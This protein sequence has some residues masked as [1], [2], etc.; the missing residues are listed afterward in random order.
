M[1]FYI[2]YVCG[3]ENNRLQQLDFIILGGGASGLQ[4]AHR[5]S[6]SAAHKASSILSL[7]ATST[8]RT[9][10]LGVFGKQVKE[11][12]TICSKT[13]G[14]RCNLKVKALTRPLIWETLHT[15][16]FEANRIMTSSIKTLRKPSQ[17]ISSMNVVLALA[18]KAL[19]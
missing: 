2:L 4:L 12:G 14:A 1:G 13:S 15:R 7:K 5:L 9:I 8:K 10:G 6:K 18:I 11:S 3:S 16:C 17:L 19:M